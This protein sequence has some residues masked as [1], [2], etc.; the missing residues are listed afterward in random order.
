MK[1]TFC[2]GIV[3]YTC[4]IADTRRPNFNGKTL[5][6]EFGIG[7]LFSL[8]WRIRRRVMLRNHLVATLSLPYGQLHCNRIFISWRGKT[9][10]KASHQ[11]S[12]C[13]NVLFDKFCCF[14]AYIVDSLFARFL[15]CP[16]A[17]FPSFFQLSSSQSAR[18]LWREGKL[19]QLQVCKFSNFLE[20]KSL[21]P[22]SPST[23]CNPGGGL[24]SILLPWV[25]DC[26]Q[27]CDSTTGFS[28]QTQLN[29]T[30]QKTRLCFP[31]LGEGVPSGSGLPWYR[32]PRWLLSGVKPETSLSPLPLP[33]RGCEECG[34]CL[35]I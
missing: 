6:C 16:F 32:W 4:P 18:S 31:T 27:A 33:H 35:G 30:L 15:I 10:Q 14:F 12:G 22:A 17:L 7:H 9:E 19:P 2:P 5:S 25:W 20:Q 24:L 26:G 34:P 3:S 28:L 29:P 13:H 11:S 1:A 8:P 21:T 23:L